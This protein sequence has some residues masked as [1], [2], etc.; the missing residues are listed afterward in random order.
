MNDRSTRSAD[1]SGESPSLSVDN[2]FCAAL[3]LLHYAHDRAQ[4]AHAAPWDFALEIGELYEAGLTITDLRWLVV[5]GFVE[6]GAET[7]AYGDPHRSF[8]RSRGFNFL[9][10]TCVV[11]TTRGASFTCQV[12]QAPAA[13]NA[14]SEPPDGA[15]EGE[16]GSEFPAPNGKM[17]PE[18]TLKPHWNPARRELSL[19]SRLVKQFLV[20]AGNQEVILSAFQEED[21]PEY[22]DDPLTGN[23]GIDPK[24]RLNS[25][26]YRL[27]H[28]QL[29]LLIRFHTNGK[30]N[31][32]HWSLVR[33]TDDAPTAQRCRGT[34]G[35]CT[36][37]S[38][39]RAIDVRSMVED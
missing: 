6:H 11:L 31:G 17:Q 24:I 2:N 4:D 10:T 5:K 21:W 19:G 33:A 18:A 28:K 27:N 35:V 15:G 23:H 29:E 16:A 36:G 7:S 39:R 8:A 34:D 38:Y 37:A 22:I 32:V 12:L 14:A 20:P 9:T 26:V 13:T 3:A 25:A 1:G 30:G